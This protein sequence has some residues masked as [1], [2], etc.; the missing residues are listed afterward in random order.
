MADLK[1]W[2]VKSENGSIYGPAT[3]AT[4]I[5]WAGDGRVEPKGF[6]SRDR[7][8]WMQ[9]CL[10]AEL[11]MKWLVEV[12]PGEVYGP[13]NRNYVIRM[14]AD[15]T[16]P[17]RAK[18]YRLHELPIDR[19][20]QPETVEVPVEK[21]VEK[22][23]EKQVK[24]PVEKVVEKIVEKQVKVPVEKIVE[25]RVEVPVEKV[26]EKIVEKRVEV[27][28]E[29]IVEVS[30]DRIVERRVEVPVEKIVEKIVER[31]VEVPVELKVEKIVEKIVEVPLE[32]KVEKIVEVDKGSRARL[33]TAS[34]E[35][36]VPEVV[37]QPVAVANGAG[38]FAAA[39]KPG[40]MFGNMNRQ[41]LM[42]LEAAVQREIKEAKNRKG[43]L[44][45]FMKKKE[46]K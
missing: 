7:E 1:E 26:V 41:N 13:Y 21:V 16:L 30:V 27:P 10:L 44:G 32:V 17:Q 3:M 8:V 22:I 15:K 34:A 9:A 5:E 39:R 6:V 31:R 23:V 35:P 29:K 33:G 38:E 40:G 28:V 42:A 2:F 12:A 25:K 37:G 43:L 45:G 14:V 46:G 11:E 18:F 19:D 4:L 24:V 20:P 36:L